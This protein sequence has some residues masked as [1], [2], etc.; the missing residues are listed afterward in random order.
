MIQIQAGKLKTSETNAYE[1][2]KSIS[3]QLSWQDERIIGLGAVGQIM[4]D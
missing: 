2:A 3:F 4:D 1:S